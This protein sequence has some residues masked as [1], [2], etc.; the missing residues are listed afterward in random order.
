MGNKVIALGDSLASVP[1]HFRVNLG[2]EDSSTRVCSDTLTR[3]KG[4]ESWRAVIKSV[5]SIAK[6]EGETHGTLIDVTGRKYS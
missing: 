1:W 2:T 3:G 5:S 4:Q 6:H